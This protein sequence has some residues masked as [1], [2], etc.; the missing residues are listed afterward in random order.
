MRATELVVVFLGLAAL[1][2]GQS[3]PTD[4]TV[5][6]G[7]R[8]GPVTAS[9]VRADIKGLFPKASVAEDE[10][11]LDEGMVFPATWVARENPA[12]SL[13]IIWTGKAADAHP[14]QVFL[15]RGRRRTACK[16]HAT[17]VGGDIATGMKL[18]E[19]ETMN[20]KP[21]T[22][23]GFGWG[24][25]GAVETWDGGALDKV[26][27]HHSL[28]IALDGERKDGEFT[29]P[30]TEDEV[31]SFSGNRS[32]PSSTP[33]LRKLNPAITEILF[34]FPPPGAKACGS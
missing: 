25:G 20:G 31:V 26:D 13:A 2:T 27:C 23:H 14:K 7:V 21:F 11:E 15:C 18:S 17:G 30:L 33:A 16:W 29:V 24:Y 9:T 1:A 6:P 34:V 3:V 8:V 19:L 5:V 32:V 4:F 10:L 22:I 28:S 12:E